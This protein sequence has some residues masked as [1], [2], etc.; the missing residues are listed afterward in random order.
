MSKGKWPFSL[1]LV[2]LAA[3][4]VQ[5]VFRPMKELVLAG[6]DPVYPKRELSTKNWFEGRFQK[7]FDRKTACT[8]GFR[9]NTVQLFNQLDYSLFGTMNPQVLKGE[10]D[11]LFERVYETPVCA[12]DLADPSLLQAKADSI[13]ELDRLLKLRGKQL[14]LM[15]APN[16]WRY[17]SDKAPWSCEPAAETNYSRFKELLKTHEIRTIDC[18]DLFEQ[19]K[20]TTQHPLYA[21][22]GTHWS[23]YGAWQVV[24]YLHRA[25]EKDGFTM[26]SLE[27][28]ALE[29]I[30]EPRNTDKDLH[31]LLNV[32]V[33]APR[34]DLAYPHVTTSEDPSTKALI[35]AD[36]YYWTFV[37][38]HLHDKLWAAESPFLY[39][40]NFRY[41]DFY[42]KEA[43]EEGQREQWL[44]DSNIV[45]LFVHEPTIDEAGYG[46][47]EGAIAH[48]QQN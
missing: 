43:I 1:V 20:D 31:D 28:T 46:F 42:T 18:I 12:K 33:K 11:F 36:S 29:V 48:L 23:V 6:A 27:L 9:S 25:L 39:Y 22:S 21:Q 2:A 47:L 40:N 37:Y 16:K 38:L 32:M 34:F 13:S 24:Q 45:L 35:I 7:A 41:R 15:I 3:L 44:D 30:D 8:F 17:H 4:F 19:W 26:P 5:S 10:D 14:Y